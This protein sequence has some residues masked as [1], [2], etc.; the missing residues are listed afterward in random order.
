MKLAAVAALPLE[1]EPRTWLRGTAAVLVV[2]ALR[3]SSAGAV[4]G[5]SH[6]AAGTIVDRLVMVLQRRGAEAGFCTGIVIGPRSVLTA[7]HCAPPGAELRVHYRDGTGTPVLLRVAKVVRHPGYRADAIARRERSV[8]LAVVTLPAPLPERFEPATLSAQREARVGEGFTVAG[9]GLG[10]E[11]EA[12]SS[13]RLRE[14][15]LAA[16]APLSGVLLWAV[17]PSG[18]G[19][20]ACTGDSGGPVLD[21][22][23][24]V[25]ALTLWSAGTGS[26]RCGALTQAIW[27]APYR[28]WIQ[29]AAAP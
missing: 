20:G 24:A 12:A 26:R 1:A 16:R 8:D 21:R 2:G 7:A 18:A 11:G 6:E 4:V 15:D 28:D 23:G 19:A 17:D 5:P 14:A 29:A 27:L 3:I 22:A 13:G 25:A 9:F 10:R